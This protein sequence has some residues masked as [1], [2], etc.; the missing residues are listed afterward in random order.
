MPRFLQC[1]KR[2]LERFQ[3]P[4]GALVA[5]HAALAGLVP[6]VVSVLYQSEEISVLPS[7]SPAQLA[8]LLHGLFPFRFQAV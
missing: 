3:D 1:P 6:L 8:H 4:R 5:E 2:L 7:A